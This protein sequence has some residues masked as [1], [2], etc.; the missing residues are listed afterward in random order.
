MTDD[1]PRNFKPLVYGLIV[2]AILGGAWLS[3]PAYRQWKKQRY[4]GHAESFLSKS[5]FKNAALSARQVLAL[6]PAHLRATA[7]MCEVLARVRS[8]EVV[9]WRQLMA[10]LEPDNPTNRIALAEAALSF[11]DVPRAEQALVRV[12]P[13][14]RDSVEFHQAA[15]FVLAS[16]RKL[17]ER[18]AKRAGS[19]EP[20]S[21]E[22]IFRAALA[23]DP[24]TRDRLADMELV[25]EPRVIRGYSASVSQFANAVRRPLLLGLPRGGVTIGCFSSMQSRTS[26]RTSRFGRRQSPP[27]R[28]LRPRS[29]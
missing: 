21:D 8:P 17:A 3:R 16:Q 5:D 9:T 25:F 19:R 13:A 15:G 10:D 20:L 6:D 11:G 18:E 28:R 26:G 22:E 1:Q 24:N 29:R 7:I 14:S 23:E 27:L 12:P 2:V 4:L